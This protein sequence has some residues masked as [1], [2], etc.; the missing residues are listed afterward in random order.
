MAWFLYVNMWNILNVCPILQFFK[1]PVFLLAGSKDYHDLC[2]MSYR[3][4][5]SF[6]L[7]FFVLLFKIL[8]LPGIS[9]RFLILLYTII[10]LF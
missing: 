9:L 6:V 2:N 1:M 10:V 3:K 8:L 4:S 7:A 5:V